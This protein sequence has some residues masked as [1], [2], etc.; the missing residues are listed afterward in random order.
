MFIYAWPC[1][2]FSLF[3]VDPPPDEP[4]GFSL[5]EKSKT[6]KKRVHYMK[7]TKG[8][9]FFV[10]WPKT[11]QGDEHGLGRCLTQRFLFLLCS[12]MTLISVRSCNKLSQTGSFIHHKF[13]FE[14]KWFIYHATD[15]QT[16]SVTPCLSLCTW[17]RPQTLNRA[18]WACAGSVD[19]VS[20]RG[21]Y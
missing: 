10:S 15:G 8:G 2:K 11:D 19:P 4:K 3:H 6:S 13:K 12:V 16:S 9:F 21:G 14:I 20:A 5:E 7:F 1:F 18:L 17:L